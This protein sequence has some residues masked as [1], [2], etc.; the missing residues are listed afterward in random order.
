L[1]PTTNQKPNKLP[2]LNNNK[3]DFDVLIESKYIPD[4]LTPL[5]IDLRN[6]TMLLMESKRT[7][8]EIRND[9]DW[10]YMRLLANQIK[11]RIISFKR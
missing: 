6:K 9:L 2:H 5:I 3:H 11:S 1:T 8:N 4:D 7:I 10:S